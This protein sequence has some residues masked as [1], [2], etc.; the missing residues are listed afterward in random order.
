MAGRSLALPV[1]FAGYPDKATA[2]SQ[3]SEEDAKA[4]GFRFGSQNPYAAG[5]MTSHAG[6]ET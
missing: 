1:Q 5:H 3:K 6:Q 2:K 4:D